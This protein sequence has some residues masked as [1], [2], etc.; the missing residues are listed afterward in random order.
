LGVG[1]PAGAKFLLST[2]GGTATALNV[3]ARRAAS[4]ANYVMMHLDNAGAT[5]FAADA[6]GPF[7]GIVT[8]TGATTAPAPA[9]VTAF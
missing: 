3:W 9:G 7:V 6:G 4:T 1:I 5:T 2:S 8:R